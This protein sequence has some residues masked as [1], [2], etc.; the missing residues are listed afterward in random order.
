M[1]SY[2]YNSKVPTVS[3][4]SSFPS[5]KEPNNFKETARQHLSYLGPTLYNKVIKKFGNGILVEGNPKFKMKCLELILSI[6]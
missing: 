2:N 6:P 4:A 5:L 1:A 3:F